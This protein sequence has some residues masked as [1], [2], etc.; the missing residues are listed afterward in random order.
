MTVTKLAIAVLLGG[1]IMASAGPALAD[2]H[3]A[4]DCGSSDRM[5][6]D[7]VVGKITRGE[8]DMIY[9]SIVFYDEFCDGGLWMVKIGTPD[10]KIARVNESWQLDQFVSA[11]FA[12]PEKK[13]AEDGD[14]IIVTASFITGIGPTGAQPFT[15]RIPM[16]RAGDTWIEGEAEV[17]EE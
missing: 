10:L 16:T 17:V 3:A 12:R 9:E 5:D 15:V 7:R 13:D 14:V 4:F 6:P 1:S 8:S 11:A 2:N